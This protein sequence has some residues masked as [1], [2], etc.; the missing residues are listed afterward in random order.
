MSILSVSPDRGR[1]AFQLHQAEAET[2]AYC[3][4]MFVL[5]LRDGSVPVVIDRGGELVRET[6]DL[7]GTT[8][9]QT[10]YTKAIA[11]KWSPDGVKLAYLRRDN[12]TTQ[13]WLA[14]VGGERAAPITHLNSDVDD[15]AWTPDGQ[16][17]VIEWR[18][19][20]TKAFADIKAEGETGYLFDQRWIPFTGN[21][22]HPTPVRSEALYVDAVTGT[23][24]P[25]SSQENQLL[26]RTPKGAP[27]QAMRSATSDAGQVAWTQR[28]DS[29]DVSSYEVLRI[30]RPN[31]TIIECD[32]A[33]A[34]GIAGLWWSLDSK[35]LYFLR[36]NWHH[37]LATLYAWRPGHYGPR[38]I[39]QT[40][41]ALVG[42]ELAVDQLVCAM[43]GS[44]QPRQLV[45]INLTTGNVKTLFNPNP[46]FQNIA[47]GPARR[48]QWYN[49]KG[50]EQF[51]DL[52][53]PPDH[54]AGQRHP[55]IVVQYESR[56]FLRGGT[57]D[58]YPIQ[59]LAAN[60]FAVLSFQFP[61]NVGLERGG[62]TWDEINRIDHTD[63]ALRRNVQ[64]TLERD[65]SLAASTGAIDTDRMGITG[66]SEG[67]NMT[68]YAMINSR[69]FSVVSLSQCCED[70]TSV[71]AMG[72]PGGADFM[73]QIG[74]PYLVED[75]G[76]F[77]HQFSI[78]AN[79]D[80][81]SSPILFQVA[82]SE[83]LS[84]LE[85]VEALREAYKPFEMYVFPNEY[86]EKWQPR[87]RLAIYQRNVDWFNFW[88]QNR[89]DA[90]PAKAPQYARWA[91]LRTERQ[92]VSTS[93]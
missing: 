8:G 35:V 73:H 71:M 57:D 23:A 25:A 1:I 11:P 6:Q 88:L 43:E 31:G 51:F 16:G 53:L 87:H 33:N 79:L 72:G 40:E 63:F 85:T 48:V 61:T 82:D 58:E 65:I 13:V 50:T 67:A 68:Q 9:Y 12:G 75:N 24:R 21:R 30:R 3:V 38:R 92:R 54:T 17:I 77:W 93:R 45:A 29:K 19:A 34:T 47:L 14:S 56:G 69:L 90:D 83:W 49:A 22:P 10:G 4:G 76:S 59:L 36:Q 15:F 78:R 62:K 39:L 27:A 60:G 64:A 52:V 2:N 41:D 74:Y 55:M 86:H 46:E 18:P 42:C 81:I 7:L 70:T 91:A 84:S 28:R 5:E 66:L 20:L 32:C 26:E 44:L 37:S 80:R 89:Q